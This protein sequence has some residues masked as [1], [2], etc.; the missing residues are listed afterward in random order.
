MKRL[1][2]AFALL[3]CSKGGR[4]YEVLKPVRER[5]SAGDT[6]A[7]ARAYLE[8]LNDRLVA[9]AYVSE[10]VGWEEFEEVGKGIV[11]G[12]VRGAGGES[13]PQAW[14]RLNLSL[15]ILERL[16]DL[17]PERA[18]DL[19]REVEA[20]LEGVVARTLDEANSLWSQGDTSGALELLAQ[21]QE[22][23]STPL[24]R[25]RKRIKTLALRRAELGAQAGRLTPGMSV[26]QAESLL[27]EPLSVDTAFAALS[28]RLGVVFKWET[29]AAFVVDDTVEDVLPNP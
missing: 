21:A 3:A 6:L 12:L 7:A 24:P 2:T 5:L 20:G 25:F 17:K 26:A 1:F 11:R 28:G 16:Y 9:S 19:A 29:V 8:A 4:L 22:A 13:L 15:R 14:V 27:G 23:L 18:G 10:D